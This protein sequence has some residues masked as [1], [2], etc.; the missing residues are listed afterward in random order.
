MAAILRREVFLFKSSKYKIQ[1]SF[2]LWP[3]LFSVQIS[4][5]ETETALNYVQQ[6]TPPKGYQ[7]HIQVEHLHKV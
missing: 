3:V 1:A 4:V 6:A 5:L 2:A 7:N